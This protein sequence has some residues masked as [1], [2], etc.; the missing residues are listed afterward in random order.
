MTRIVALAAAAMLASSPVAFAGGLGAGA[1]ERPVIQPAPVVV[2]AAPALNAGLVAAG[3]I[4]VVVV[5]AALA[6]NDSGSH[7]AAE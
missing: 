6:D 4:A 3:V 5:A 7:G 1:A 2:G